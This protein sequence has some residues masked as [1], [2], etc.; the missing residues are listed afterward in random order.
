MD[1]VNLAR[2]LALLVV[3]NGVPVIL[4]RIF[5]Q[6]FSYPVDGGMTFPDGGPL[7]GPSK[8]W[9]GI[10]GSL[11]LTPVV[12]WVIGMDAM[13]GLIVAGAA[14]LGDLTSSF[15]KRRLGIAP[16]G[17]A[18]G[19]DQVPEALFPLIALNAVMNITV[20]EMA[21]TVAVFFVLELLLSRILFRLRIRKRPY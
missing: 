12:A 11:A 2:I 10:A 13:S 14:M 21:V 8:T 16:S 5:G 15:V 1:Y 20:P 9:R 18:L 3:A 4:E 7:L 17:M 6:R 19:L